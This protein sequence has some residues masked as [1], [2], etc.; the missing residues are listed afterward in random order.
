MNKKGHQK[1]LRR[2]ELF[3]NIFEFF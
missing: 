3:L 2:K 1:S